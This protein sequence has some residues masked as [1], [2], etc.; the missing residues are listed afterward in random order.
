MASLWIELSPYHIA[1]L[2]PSPRVEVEQAR[3]HMER[4]WRFYGICFGYPDGDDLWAHDGKH[5]GH[6][7][8]DEI[9]APNGRYIGE[10]RSGNRLITDGNEKSKRLSSFYPTRSAGRA[11]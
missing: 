9:Y 11:C 7:H 3:C 10:L 1:L 5:V 4:G 8:S 6:F 2:L